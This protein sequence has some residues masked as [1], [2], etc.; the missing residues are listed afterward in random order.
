MRD[1]ASVKSFWEQFVKRNPPTPAPS[2][3]SASDGS[4]PSSSSSNPTKEGK[5]PKSELVMLEA[6]VQKSH[7]ELIT[8][9]QNN[10]TEFPDKWKAKTEVRRALIISRA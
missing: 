7:Q 1:E 4:S 8:L 5:A 3:S 10:K 6:A 2:S 9:Y